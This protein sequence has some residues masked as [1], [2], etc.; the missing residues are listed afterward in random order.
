MTQISKTIIP[1]LGYD[2][3]PFN[4]EYFWNEETG[5][6][7]ILEINPRISQSHSPLF[8][9]VDGQ[10]HHHIAIKTALQ[11]RPDFPSR[12]GAFPYAAKFMHRTFED[13]IVRKAP[14]IKE[15]KKLRQDIPELKVINLAV[16]GQRLSDMIE[17]D[18]YS[19]ELANIYIGGYNKEDVFAKYQRVVQGLG[20]EIEKTTAQTRHIK[21]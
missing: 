1:A 15:I 2:N 3:A 20:Y 12:Q 17:Q 16:T 13:G 8:R 21:A 11:Q 18:S 5:Q 19:Y 4:I 6:I 14:G 7:K 9:L 10:S